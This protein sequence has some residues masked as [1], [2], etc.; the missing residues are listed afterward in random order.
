VYAASL[1]HSWGL[2]HGAT[3]VGGR[4][5]YEIS[6]PAGAPVVVVLGGISAHCH[7]TATPER[8]EPGWWQGLVGPGRAVDPE[9]VR[10]L[11]FDY[12]GGN[13]SS[14]GPRNTR[15][16]EF[17]AVTTADQ[18]RALAHLLDELGV[19][20]LEAFVGASYGGMVALAFAA[21]FPRRL[22]R[23]V[24]VS[25]AHR[26][27]PQ[28]I[29]WRSLQRKIVRLARRQGAAHEGLV[30]S[31]GIAMVTYRSPDELEQRFGTSPRPGEAGFRFPVDDYLEARGED[32]AR[33]FHPDAFLCLSESIDLHQVDPSKIEAASTLVAV[34]S[35][36]LVPIEHMWALNR[37]LRASEWVEIAS[38]YGH[39]AFLKET[40][41]LN[42][43]LG[44]CLGEG[45]LPR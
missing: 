20:R 22:G 26:S 36:Q 28:A 34:R 39:D 2:E 21:L 11:A 41:T 30:L 3:L 24:M 32:F 44:S 12:L 1:P 5:A 6:G 10:V 40:E 7:V 35:D 43:I 33:T 37:C 19:R 23:L 13:G 29:A 18:A 38:L 27:H 15:A 14:T 45:R 25:A 9:R 16:E 8:P 4:V 31:R 42:G 17:P